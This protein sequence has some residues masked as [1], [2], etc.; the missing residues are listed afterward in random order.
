MFYGIVALQVESSAFYLVL[1]W[2]YTG[3]MKI[4]KDQIDEVQR[5]CKQCKLSQLHSDI[6]EAWDRTKKFG[7]CSQW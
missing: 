5:I 4:P 6:A 1:E 7:K 3:Q 2:I